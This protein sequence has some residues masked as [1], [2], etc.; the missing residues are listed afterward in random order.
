MDDRCRR[1]GFPPGQ[2]VTIPQSSRPGFFN[3]SD[4]TTDLVCE[5][6]VWSL[7]SKSKISKKKKKKGLTD[8]GMATGVEKTPVCETVVWPL[9][10]GCKMCLKKPGLTDRGVATGVTEFCMASGGLIF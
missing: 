6:V 3:I 8:C 9:T 2:P 7:T 1:S 4:H 10:S 5:T